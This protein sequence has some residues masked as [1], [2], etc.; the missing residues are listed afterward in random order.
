MPQR[1]PAGFD[2][3]SGGYARRSIHPGSKA[4]VGLALAV[5]SLI[6]SGLRSLFEEDDRHFGLS[7]RLRW[8]AQY[9][10][11]RSVRCPRGSCSRLPDHQLSVT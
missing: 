9:G 3:G 4:M 10:A 7:N 1:L 8:R 2:S 11:E 6:R 5:L